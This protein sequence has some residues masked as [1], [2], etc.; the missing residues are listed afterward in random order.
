MPG[1][2]IRRF[3]NKEVKNA[4]CR[5]TYNDVSVLRPLKASGAKVRISLLLKS[6]Q[7]KLR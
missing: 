7:K 3:K 4:R 2:L 5:F 6:L 1:K